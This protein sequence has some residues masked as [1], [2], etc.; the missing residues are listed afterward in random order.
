VVVVGASKC[1]DLNAMGLPGGSS[2]T[3]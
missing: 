2:R 3:A 1:V